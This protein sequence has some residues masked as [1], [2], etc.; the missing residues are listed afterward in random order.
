MFLP[1]Q[2]NTT[3]HRL[4]SSFSRLLDWDDLKHLVNSSSKTHKLNQS[5]QNSQCWF[6]STVVCGSVQ[7]NHSEMGK[8][9][10]S[11]H[12]FLSVS[13]RPRSYSPG[14][15]RC[16]SPPYYIL[17]LQTDPCCSQRLL[18]PVE[19][20]PVQLSP[21]QLSPVQLSPVELSPT[22]LWSEVVV[23]SDSLLV[24]TG[25]SIISSR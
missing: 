4:N 17:W 12:D 20:S 24:F 11:T 16:K 2:K 23:P 21:V 1:K 9:S 8:H 3:A 15:R 10:S 5:H 7:I 18:S 14:Q 22:A 25:K 13:S 6:V 19:L